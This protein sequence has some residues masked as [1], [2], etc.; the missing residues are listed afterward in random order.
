MKP[1]PTG[2][3]LA[4]A[5]AICDR[6][7]Q[8]HVQQLVRPARAPPPPADSQAGAVRPPLLLARLV[9]GLEEDQVTRAG[10]VAVP[11][12]EEQRVGLPAPLALAQG[13]GCAAAAGAGGGNGEADGSGVRRQQQQQQQQQVEEEEEQQRQQAQAAAAQGEEQAGPAAA[14]DDMLADMLSCEDMLAD[15]MADS[16][17]SLDL[18]RACTAP[19]GHP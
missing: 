1:L 5:V 4:A 9:G 6:A 12:Q 8:L 18:L 2:P 10:P 11:H 7:A 15:L 19:T 14:C 16:C 3:K 13:G 17:L